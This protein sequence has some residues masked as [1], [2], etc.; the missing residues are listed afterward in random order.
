M[1]EQRPSALGLSATIQG[2][3]ECWLELDGELTRKGG[4]SSSSGSS[5]H[6]A[7]LDL[8]VL[9]A[10]REIDGFAHT[11]IHMLMDDDRTYTPPALNT[12]HLLRAIVL[13]IGHF[14]GPQT[15]VEIAYEFAQDVETV[16][17]RAWNIARPTGRALIPI[18]P[19]VVDGCVGKMRVQIDRDRPLDPGSLALWQPDAVCESDGGHVMGARLYA[20][21]LDT[22]T[23]EL[24]ANQVPIP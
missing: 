1:S 3:I 14:A 18:G 19:C 7:P 21:N 22:P 12:P 24:L 20:Q 23:G 5:E 11:Y 9:D 13:R 6:G 4:P 17:N 2:M 10:K 8:S 15:D 16:S